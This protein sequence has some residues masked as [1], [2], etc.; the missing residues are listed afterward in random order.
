MAKNKKG[1]RIDGWEQLRNFYSRVF[2][3]ELDLR[4]HHVSLY[5]FLLQ[6]NNRN[7][8][9]EWFKCPF[10]LAMTGACIGS[11]STYY[12]SLKHLQ[13]QKLIQYIPGVNDWKAPRIS[14]I[15]LLS[16]SEQQRVPLCEPVSGPLFNPPFE[17]QDGQVSGQLYEQLIVPLPEQVGEHIYKQITSNVNNYLTS[18]WE[19]LKNK[20]PLTI[21]WIGNEKINDVKFFFEKKFPAQCESLK[22]KYK[23][24]YEKI[25]REFSTENIEAAWK[26]EQDLRKH[27]VYYMKSAVQ[28]QSSNGNKVKKSDKKEK[29]HELSKEQL[30]TKWKV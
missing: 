28:N 12:K 17:Q 6:Q 20:T 3:G 22:I 10:D 4:P 27:V 30:K 7:M 8:W 23:E 5:Q 18:N 26:D 24:S 19:N 15:P 29:S 21:F 13:E 2:S 9:A 25:F 1:Y 16:T 14:I 11:R